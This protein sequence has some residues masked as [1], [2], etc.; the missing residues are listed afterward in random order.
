MSLPAIAIVL[1]VSWSGR[2]SLSRLLECEIEF[3]VIP[4]TLASPMLGLFWRLPVVVCPLWIR[5]L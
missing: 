3:M 4:P 5:L 2:A 1:E